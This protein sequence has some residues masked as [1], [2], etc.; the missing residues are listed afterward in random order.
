MKNY[1]VCYLFL[2]DW[3]LDQ[4]WLKNEYWCFMKLMKCLEC[5]KVDST[6]AYK[7]GN[8]YSLP[9]LDAW[10]CYLPI[11]ATHNSIWIGLDLWILL[12][13]INTRNLVSRLNFTNV[14]FMKLTNMCR[15]YEFYD[16]HD[17]HWVWIV[18]ALL[19]IWKNIDIKS[20]IIFIC[21]SH[22]YIKP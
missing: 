20:W 21:Y 18:T 7:I 15:F 2:N 12:L 3:M 17:F 9:K 4:E 8:S 10:N 13:T 22:Y 14:H 6:T 5:V 19:F 1:E 16:F 11:D